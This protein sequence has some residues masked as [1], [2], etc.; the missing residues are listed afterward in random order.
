L[1]AGLIDEMHLASMPVLMGKGENLFAGL[2]LN[3]LG[4]KCAE[5]IPGDQATHIFLRK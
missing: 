3:A 5:R 4:F 1:Q 2:D